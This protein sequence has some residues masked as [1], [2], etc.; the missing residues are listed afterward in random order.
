MKPTL[1]LP[2]RNRNG[3]GS[4]IAAIDSMAAAWDP[5]SRMAASRQLAAG[6]SQRTATPSRIRSAKPAIMR[7][8]DSFSLGR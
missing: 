4:E 3:I 1:G 5:C 8:S 2:P 6:Y 7:S